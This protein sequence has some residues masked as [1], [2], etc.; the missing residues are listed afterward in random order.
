[1]PVDIVLTQFDLKVDYDG[2]RQKLKVRPGSKAERRLEDLIAG[3]LAVARPKVA[4][5]EVRPVL[6]GDGLVLLEGTIIESQLLERQL[7]GQELAFPYL[8]TGGPELADWV[9]GLS[10]LDQYLADELANV[11]L[12]QTMAEVEAYLTERYG[13]AQVSAMNPG[14]LPRE[15]PLSGQVPLFSLM[16]DLAEQIGIYLKPSLLMVPGK[17]G[18]GIFFKTSEK[19]HNCQ[20]C[21]K[22]ECPARRAP[23]A[24]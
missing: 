12:R 15:W 23:L 5:K 17:C 19:F 21:H 11:I 2:V 13:L 10:G 14:S 18:S 3:A 7:T 20:L 9:A 8:A 6:K 1:M 22:L 24:M 16:G 4:L